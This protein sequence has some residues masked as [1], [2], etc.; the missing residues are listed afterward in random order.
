MIY[1]V[2]LNN[3]LILKGNYI[4]TMSD[5]PNQLIDIEKAIASKDE[6]LLKRI[7]RFI[8]NYLKR[9]VHQ[10]ELNDIVIRNHGKPPFEFI[11]NSLKDFDISVRAEGLEN[12]K[13]NPRVII[14]ANHPLGGLD[15]LSLVKVVGENLDRGVKITA[16][17]LLMNVVALRPV[18]LG[19]NKHGTNAKSYIKEMQES[20]ESNIPIIFFPA[21][22]ISRRI[23]GKIVDLEWKRTFIKKAVEH[24]R[25][26]IPT[27]VSG[28]VS[29]FFYR[30][31]NLRKF[32]GIKQNI[33][34]LYLPD[35]MFKRKWK[36]L[37][38]RFG[39]PIP[40]Q[41][42]TRDKKPDE[43]AEIVKKEVYSIGQKN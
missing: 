43:W 35:Q 16:N 11:D 31:A 33:E 26:V 17:D 41:T 7:P 21:G 38:I 30:L 8:I 2:F 20:F 19:V 27:H 37:V 40:W 29:G 4:G 28:R 12:L 18:F 15:G 25:D 23:K 36:E 13:G 3:I 42:F 5:K 39:E 32:L 22:L 1:F 14:A 10:D 24:K 34:M 9:V 6:K